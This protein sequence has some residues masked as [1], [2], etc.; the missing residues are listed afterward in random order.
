MVSSS[1][2]RCTSVR[3]CSR[4][5]SPRA[6]W[7]RTSSAS[8]SLPGPGE[9][10]GEVA[11]AITGHGARER[12]EQRTHRIEFAP[13]SAATSASKDSA[14]PR[15]RRRA[16]DGSSNAVDGQ[17][18]RRDDRAVDQRHQRITQSQAKARAAHH[19][20]VDA[21][22]FHAA[23]TAPDATAR[24]RPRP[25]RSRRLRAS[26]QL[27]CC[28]D[29]ARRDPAPDRRPTC[30]GAAVRPRS[31]T[32]RVSPVASSLPRAAWC[33]SIRARCRASR[34]VAARRV[35]RPPGACRRARKCS[36][37]GR[38]SSRRSASGGRR[39]SITFRR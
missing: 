33:S 32:W 20:R 16:S 22:P 2:S 19:V 23:G 27:R 21:E 38:M 31:P 29:R 39:T 8:S 1:S 35:R 4:K 36:A 37:S 9:A 10:E 28:R 34:D 13:R 25:A 11:V 6:L 5:V 18:Q 30:A 14:T 17:R 15:R 24:V 3:R 12:A 7:A 26:T